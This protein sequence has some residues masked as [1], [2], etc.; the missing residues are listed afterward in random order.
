M[1]GVREP[2]IDCFGYGRSRLWICDSDIEMLNAI[3]AGISA[4]IE[5]VVVDQGA[6]GPGAEIGVLERADYLECSCTR[7]IALRNVRGW[8]HEREC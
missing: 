4:L 7:P 2:C 1:R 3:P 6:V 5:V 8:N